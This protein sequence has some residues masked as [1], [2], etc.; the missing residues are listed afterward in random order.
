MDFNDNDLL[1]IENDVYE[2][3]E[4]Y[5]RTEVI[6]I[7]S[8][9]FYENLVEDITNV[10]HDYWMDC[11]ICDDEDYD[12]V[13]TIVENLLDVYLDFSVIPRR[14]ISYQSLV[15]PSEKNTNEMLDKIN[16]LKNLPQPKQK[17]KEWYEFRYNLITAS[18]IWKALSSTAQRNSLIYEK[19]KPLNTFQSSTNT[20]SAMHW[21]I[22]YE[23]LT[24]MW[25][26]HV[27]QTKLDDFGC[28]MHPLYKCIG[29]SPDGINTDPSN[30]VLFGRMVEIKNI[31]NRDITGSPK[32]EYWVQTQVQ[33]ETCDLEECDF[34]ETRFKEHE[35][36]EQFY[37]DE[38]HEYKGVILHFMF[39][40]SNM[41]TDEISANLSAINSPNYKY[42]PFNI[43]RTKQS[44]DAWINEIKTTNQ[45]EMIL[46]ST[47]YWY[48]D[49]HSCVLIQRNRA[50]F[51]AAAPIIEDTWQTILKERT[52]G[53]QHRAA[54]KRA[55]KVEPNIH[56]DKIDD[57]TSQS[58]R[59]MPLMNS[60]C[61]VKLD[62]DAFAEETL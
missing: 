22:K 27:Y 16:A 50:W 57:S 28:I 11:G 36:E 60:I 62:H 20:E 31:V 41:T 59:N 33:M 32:E 3:I 51:Q 19:C 5:L 47:L 18:N 35:S 52:D 7:S 29:A 54:K 49:E 14:S 37:A 23:P 10:I 38:D 24:V 46:F 39:K 25:Y 44:I 53:Y 58:I 30:K 40:T 48:L 2:N 34:V 12:E 21:G 45:S 43:P 61:L 42:M 4:E 56:V 15:E 1:D 17:T 55:I 6:N 13:E 26:E 8:P 9:H